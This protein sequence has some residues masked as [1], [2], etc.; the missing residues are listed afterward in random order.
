MRFATCTP[1]SAADLKSFVTKTMEETGIKIVYGCDSLN[2]E[3][4]I[5]EM[6]PKT[7]KDHLA[8]ALIKKIHP[9]LLDRLATIPRD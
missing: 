4:W 7:M 8:A 1:C 9:D 6:L 2:H 3:D 5:V